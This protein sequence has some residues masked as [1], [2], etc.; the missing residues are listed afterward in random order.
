[1]EQKMAPGAVK[2]QV[3]GLV[4]GTDGKKVAGRVTCLSGGMFPCTIA[5]V[6]FDLL[7]LGAG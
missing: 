7:P 3:Q 4:Q 2:C 5:S 1:M 6:E